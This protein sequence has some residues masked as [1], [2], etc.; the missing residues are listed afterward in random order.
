MNIFRKIH[1]PLLAAVSVIGLGLSSCKSSPILKP[2]TPQNENEHKDH[3]EAS[4]AEITLQAVRVSKDGTVTMLPKA[5]G[6]KYDLN[7]QKI[8]FETTKEGFMPKAGMPNKFVVRGGLAQGKTPVDPA[9]AGWTDE[10][11]DIAK[12]HNGDMLY[13]MTIRTYALDGDDMTHEFATAEES[14]IHQIFFRT[15]SRTGTEFAPA[16]AVYNV[17]DYR[18]LTYYYA[19]K[20]PWDKADGAFTGISNPIGLDGYIEFYQPNTMFDLKINL[21]HAQGFTKYL[22]DGKSTSPFYKPTP[23]QE[24]KG[25]WE[26]LNLTIPVIV[27]AGTE[28]GYLISGEYA[29]LSKE[30]KL[31]VQKL[32]K[33]LGV[34]EQEAFDNLRIADEQ[35]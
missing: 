27:Y 7:Y 3:E 33:A 22:E 14:K 8:V 13:F 9:S 30:E 17:D 5:V 35:Q 24:S 19:D 20:T 4:R 21:L 6:S 16:N 1:L 2:D 10:T 15:D 26:D 34:S 25:D 18:F 28:D 23:T 11:F 29:D 12:A 31:L 32:A